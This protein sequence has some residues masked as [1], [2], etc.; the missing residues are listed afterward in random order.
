MVATWP[1]SSYSTVS[2]MPPNPRGLPPGEHRLLEVG[3][4]RAAP[5]EGDLAQLIQ[6][7][8]RGRVD[9]ALADRKLDHRAVALGDGEQAR[10]AGRVELPQGD[11]VR[12]LHLV[13]VGHQRPAAG[14]P[15]HHRRDEVGRARDVIVEQPEDAVGVDVEAQFLME[16]P[17]RRLLSR[18][19]RIAA[20]AWERPL[21]GMRTQTAG[22]PRDEVTRLAVVLDWVARLSTAG[23]AP[24]LAR[25]GAGLVGSAPQ[26]PLVVDHTHGH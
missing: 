23:S 17:P 8:C 11:G 6:E 22:A 7:D 16:L 3:H 14:G 21:P 15:R 12:R 13:V 2:P 10:H 19:S 24:G 5:V 26:A 1:S 20:A 4:A 25:P 18:F 9:V